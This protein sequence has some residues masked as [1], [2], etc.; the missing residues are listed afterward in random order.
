MSLKFYVNTCIMSLLSSTILFYLFLSFGLYVW[1]LNNTTYTL[2]GFF[3]TFYNFISF[4]ILIF[5]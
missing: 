5:Y 2:F 4:I 3:F 1:I